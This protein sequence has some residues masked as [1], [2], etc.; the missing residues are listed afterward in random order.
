MAN[1]GKKVPWLPLLAGGAVLAVAGVG[2]YH[3]YTTYRKA[4]PLIKALQ[5][6]QKTTEDA[7]KVVTA[8]KEKTD[9]AQQAR[10]AADSKGMDARGRARNHAAR[11][12]EAISRGDRKTAV[13]EYVAARAEY[14]TAEQRFREAGRAREGDL[15]GT[16]LRQFKEEFSAAYP[17]AVKKADAR[18]KELQ[19]KATGKPAWMS[20][21]GVVSRRLRPATIQTGYPQEDD[22]SLQMMG[23]PQ[24]DDQSLQLMGDDEEV[25]LFRGLGGRV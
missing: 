14:M 13:A 23:Y 18:A 21:K 24:N 8:V 1:G 2:G 15:M 9:V 5:R 7:R 6:A 4:E 11:T 19:R 17:D 25:P 3:I 20:T 10:S 22:L 16:E 12:R